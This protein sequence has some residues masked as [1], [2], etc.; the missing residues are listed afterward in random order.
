M[1]KINEQEAK[2]ILLSRGYNKTVTLNFSAGYENKS[3]QHSFSTDIITIS[4]SIKVL[5]ADK[6][7]NLSVGDGFQLRAGIEH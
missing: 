7:H 1:K 5:A 6:V 4:G 3:H 2:K